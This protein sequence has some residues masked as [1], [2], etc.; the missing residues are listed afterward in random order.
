MVVGCPC[1]Q[2][3]HQPERDEEALLKIVRRDTF[4]YTALLNLTLL[5][6]DG[7]R[8]HY[9]KKKE[10]DLTITRA[11]LCRNFL[12]GCFL[13]AFPNKMSS[14]PRSEKAAQCKDDGNEHQ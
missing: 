14:Q 9:K 2:K 8:G 13:R 11:L 12:R 4:T 10:I 7:A 6:D 5:T 3:D 1:A